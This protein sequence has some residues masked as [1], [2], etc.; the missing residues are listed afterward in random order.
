[1]NGV[2]RCN[3]HST[4]QRLKLADTPL[5]QIINEFTFHYAKIK[6]LHINAPDYGET[7]LHSTMQ[8]LKPIKNLN[9]E[10]NE[11]IYI[12]LCKD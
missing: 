11:I 2:S 6:T 1:M 3:L 10:A 12:P 5:C 4:M 8:R 7:D 9:A